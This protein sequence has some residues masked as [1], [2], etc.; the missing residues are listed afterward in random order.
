M[1]SW[2]NRGGAGGGTSLIGREQVLPLGVL[3]NGVV[4][5]VV[6]VRGLNA[7]GPLRSHAAHRLADVERAHVL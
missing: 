5:E 4:A 6:L 7:E 2:I 1:R 3:Q